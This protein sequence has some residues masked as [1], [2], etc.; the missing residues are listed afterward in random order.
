MVHKRKSKTP[1]TKSSAT[2]PS[3]DSAKPKST[4]TV[5][6][7]FHVL[8]K[9]RANLQKQALGSST[10]ELQSIESELAAL[11]GLEAYQNMSAI[12]QGKDRGGGSEVIL[13]QWLKELKPESNSAEGG[14]KE[15]G[16]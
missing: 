12:G 3:L 7:R 10:R 9:R 16:G 4:R 5:I 2:K 15:N 14:K 11:G 1:I 8:L 13:I 6:R